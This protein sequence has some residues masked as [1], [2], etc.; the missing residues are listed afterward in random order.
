MEKINNL[1]HTFCNIHCCVANNSDSYFLQFFPK[2]WRSTFF[3]IHDRLCFKG[4]L[5]LIL[6]TTLSKMKIPNVRD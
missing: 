6:T 3:T 1:I 4:M 2:W 5:G